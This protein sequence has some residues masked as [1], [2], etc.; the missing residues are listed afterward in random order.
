MTLTKEER[1]EEFLA[2]YGVLG[3]KWGVRKDRDALYKEAWDREFSRLK[4][5][6]SKN[7]NPFIGMTKRDLL[8]LRASVQSKINK[9][10]P[11]RIAASMGMVGKKPPKVYKEAAKRGDKTPFQKLTPEEKT[12]IVIN[13]ATS[14]AMAYASKTLARGAFASSIVL[15]GG[16]IAYKKI[17]NARIKAGIRPVQVFLLG[18]YGLTVASELADLKTNVNY[19]KLSGTRTQIDRALKNAK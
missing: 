18:S 6:A 13:G 12:S 15:F 16:N 11:N 17:S 4:A 3:M 19:R 8:A 14:N 2:H 9:M 10:D 7:P 1:A 5:E